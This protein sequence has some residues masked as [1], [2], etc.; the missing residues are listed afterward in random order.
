M[1]IDGRFKDVRAAYTQMDLL[2][3]TELA[4]FPLWQLTVAG[5]DPDNYDDMS[6]RGG[7]SWMPAGRPGASC[8]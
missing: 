5:L 8:A 4:N 7:R 3:G 1:G 2:N 6:S